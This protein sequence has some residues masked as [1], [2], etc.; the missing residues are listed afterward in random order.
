MYHH[1]PI[2]SREGAD[3]GPWFAM[4]FA[5]P[6]RSKGWATIVKLANSDSDSYLFKPRGL[7]PA[8]N[9]RVTFDSTGTTAIIDGARL[10]RE[11]LMIRLET[12]LSSELLLFQAQ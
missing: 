7:N 1:A 12:T 11:G 5:A 8:K 10:Q 2:T 9:Y 4:E 3:S 6:D